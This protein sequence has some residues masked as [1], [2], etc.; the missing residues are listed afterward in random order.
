MD[1]GDGIPA[2]ILSHVFEPHF[3][4]RTSGSGLG[5]AICRAVILAHGGQI[6]A[7]NRASGGFEVRI[8]LPLPPE[9]PS[10]LPAEDA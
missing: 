8:A 3:S 1:D 6:A 10:P 2:D 4:T 7:S 5:L 9:P